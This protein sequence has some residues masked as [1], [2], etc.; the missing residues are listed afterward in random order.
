MTRGKDHVVEV[1]RRAFLLR[2]EL[3]RGK[4]FARALAIG[5]RGIYLPFAL[6]TRPGGGR[7]ARFFKVLQGNQLRGFSEVVFQASA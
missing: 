1:G 2:V 7:R 6:T 3:S 4:K 5:E